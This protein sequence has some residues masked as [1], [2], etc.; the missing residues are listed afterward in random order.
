M[1]QSVPPAAP[2][3]EELVR[4][5]SY[6]FKG[7]IKVASAATMPIVPVS[8]STAVVSVDEVLN[9]PPTLSTYL[10]QDIT[11]QLQHPM[12]V[13]Q[14]AAF[15]TN[16]WIFGENLAVS[17][18]GHLNAPADSAVLRREIAAAQHAIADQQLA[19]LL[20]LASFVLVG[21]VV[22]TNLL[23]D[24]RVQQVISFH[25]PLWRAATLAVR[26]VLKGQPDGQQVAVVYPSSF[27]RMWSTAPKFP[28]HQEGI[29]LL[30]TDQVRT[31]PAAFQ[32]TGLTALNPLDYQSLD[33]LA[34]IEFLLKQG[35]GNV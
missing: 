23:L 35:G 3:L 32:I 15:F 21:A 24:Q 17:E 20:Q 8:A 19:D 12:Q 27:D 6:M 9:A 10:H 4:Q 26:S 33:E 16:P 28:L 22:S 1:K 13:G 29:Y 14:T 25:N 7:T 18:I 31:L 30:H 11:I 2:A 34:R 5:S